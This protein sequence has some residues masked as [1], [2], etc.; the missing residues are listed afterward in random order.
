MACLRS[1]TDARVVWLVESDGI[2]EP[3]PN[4]AIVLTPGGGRLGSLAGGTLDGFLA[5]APT[6]SAGLLWEIEFTITDA[7]IAGVREGA[8]ATLAVVDAAALPEQI[9]NLL[10]GREAVGISARVEGRLLSDFTLVDPGA[11]QA[12]DDERFVSIFDPVPR[13]ALFGSGPIIDAVETVASFVGWQVVRAADPERA[14]GLMNGLAKIDSALVTGHDVEASSRVLAA[15]IESEVGYIG[16]LG[17]M[18][19]QQQRA[20][21]LA[22]RG[23]TDL[24]R[25]HGPAGIDIGADSPPT[26]ALSILAEAVA[27]HAKSRT[28]G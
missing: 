8:R 15:A 14:I 12:I 7:L 25:V 2:G 28:S 23:V 16:S 21:W 3:D 9:W 27:A 5:D 20:D 4:D 17:S 11:V 22:Y 19:M 24:S 18:K 13:M 10:L 6:T 1:G 26:I